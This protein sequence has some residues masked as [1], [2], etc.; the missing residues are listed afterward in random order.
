MLW[1]DSFYCLHCF[2]L[3]HFSGVLILRKK[4]MV[5]CLVEH[6]EAVSEYF[7]VSFLTLICVNR[8]QSATSLKLLMGERNNTDYLVTVV[9]VLGWD[10][11][12][13]TSEESF[14]EVDVF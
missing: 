12:I 14:L 4:L 11:Y 13:A 5:T 3:A 10:I 7:Q 8:H 9:T 6:G 2:K 1:F